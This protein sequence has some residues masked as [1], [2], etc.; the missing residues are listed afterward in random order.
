MFFKTAKI[1]VK[2][3]SQF[4]SLCEAHYN[5]GNDIYFKKA[6]MSGR[7]RNARQRQHGISN[8]LD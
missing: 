2:K 7:A 1:I 8:I 5:K 4:L 6:E 3:L